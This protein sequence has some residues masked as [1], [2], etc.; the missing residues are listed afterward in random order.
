MATLASVSST[1]TESEV[2]IEDKSEDQNALLQNKITAKSSRVIVDP[3]KVHDFPEPITPLNMNE[4]LWLIAIMT[5]ITLIITIIQR[6][7]IFKFILAYRYQTW[8]ILAW[9][10]LIIAV[11]ILFISTF[12]D[13]LKNT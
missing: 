9:T 8:N 2:T 4:M 3:I 11:T 10:V 5:L 7:C 13:F 6:Y 1:E 12:N